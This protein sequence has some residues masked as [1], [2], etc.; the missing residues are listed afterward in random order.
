VPLQPPSVPFSS[1]QHDLQYQDNLDPFLAEL[2][3]PSDPAFGTSALFFDTFA[4]A[5]P[6]AQES[7]APFPSIDWPFGLNDPSLSL[8]NFSSDLQ[9]IA[10]SGPS[11][12]A[13]NSPPGH[14]APQANTASSVRRSPPSASVSS[15]SKLSDSSTRHA[16]YPKSKPAPKASSSSASINSTTPPD[17]EGDLDDEDDKLLRRNRNTLAARK[18]RQKR[19][20]RIAELEEALAVM[21]KERDALRLNLSRKDAEVGILKEMLA[22]RPRV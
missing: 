15:L 22:A 5:P 11:S 17:P 13:S 7:P 16:P 19:T 10:P 20:D 21:A 3:P 14:V 18:Y 8:N 12:D 1:R 4:L 6:F 9:S 2:Y